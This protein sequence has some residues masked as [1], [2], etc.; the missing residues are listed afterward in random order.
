MS[1]VDVIAEAEASGVRLEVVEDKLRWRGRASPR[2]LDQLRAHK[3]EV[4]AL[5]A[6][7]WRDDPA[8]APDGRLWSDEVPFPLEPPP[9]DDDAFDQMRAD[10][11]AAVRDLIA[12]GHKPSKVRRM[13][14]LTWVE[15]DEI[16]GGG[17]S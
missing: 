17:R 5:L 7:P 4:V 10:L 3:V 2:L 8:E 9:F 11:A 16:V 6:E 1:A 13:F 14:G 12:A 15:L